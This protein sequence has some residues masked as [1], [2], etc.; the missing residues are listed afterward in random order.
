M[1]VGCGEQEREIHGEAR[2]GKFGFV[3]INQHAMGCLA[4]YTEQWTETVYA[5][6]LAIIIICCQEL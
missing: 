6:I 4:V 2:A 1:R 5:K 3:Y